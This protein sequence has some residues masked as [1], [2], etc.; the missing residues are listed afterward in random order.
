MAAKLATRMAGMIASF[1][2]LMLLRDDWVRRPAMG[3]VREC[4]P[5]GKERCHT[6]K[7]RSTDSGS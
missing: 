1:M 2:A 4:L 6:S 5:V 7:V 3:S